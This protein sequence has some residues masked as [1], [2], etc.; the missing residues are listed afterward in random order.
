MVIA[1][2][3]IAGIV[4]GFVAGI[5]GIGGGLLLVPF[6]LS[7]DF[8]PIQA[9]STSLMAITLTSTNGTIQNYLRG[10]INLS[11]VF[12]LAIPSM[13]TVSLGAM[14]ATFI[15][16][17][18]LAISFALFLLINIYLVK[19][20]KSLN[21]SLTGNYSSVIKK[22]LTGSLS[23]FL[24]GIFGVGGGVVLVPLQIAL[25]GE[26]IKN[27]VI[28]SLAVISLTSLSGTLT[29]LILGN[30]LLPQGILLGI[31]GIIG[32]TISGKLLVKIPDKWVEYFFIG[33]MISLSAYILKDYI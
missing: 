21:H 33:L 9:T 24:A 6:L 31:G 12:S 30:I 5:L 14:V 10:S 11:K 2:Y 13:V 23:G 17:N 1:T 8:S 19:L 7:L 3:L 28:N 25:L 27:A 20:K 4:S 22:L 32:I 18:V 26:N 16:D 15:P 29:N